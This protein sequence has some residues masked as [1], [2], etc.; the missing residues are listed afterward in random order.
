MRETRP[1]E[2]RRFQYAR[3]LERRNDFNG[4]GPLKDTTAAKNGAGV[5]AVPFAMRRTLR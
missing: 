2:R 4:T 1:L 3:P 5:S